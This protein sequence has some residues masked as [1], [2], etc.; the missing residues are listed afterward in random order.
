[1]L[2]NGSRTI[3]LPGGENEDSSVKL[4]VLIDRI[5]DKRL[6]FLVSRLLKR[7]FVEPL[8]PCAGCGRKQS[9]YNATCGAGR[10]SM[11]TC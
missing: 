5:T 3:W 8:T 11:R 9:P 6:K 7:P 4:L 10:L 1:M 2:R